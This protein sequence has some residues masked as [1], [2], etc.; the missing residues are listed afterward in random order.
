MADFLGVI[1]FDRDFAPCLKC[2]EASDQCTDGK[3]GL[4][5]CCFGW[6]IEEELCSF[7][8]KKN[9]ISSQIFTVR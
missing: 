9:K 3:T 4:C 2:H 8:K 6:M 7:Q 1:P 5:W